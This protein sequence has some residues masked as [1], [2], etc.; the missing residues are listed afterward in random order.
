M[1]AARV[2]KQPSEQGSM[3]GGVAP[4]ACW[5]ELVHT[6]SAQADGTQPLRRQQ[7]STPRSKLEE[8]HID[9]RHVKCGHSCNSMQSKRFGQG[10]IHACHVRQG[11]RGH[12]RGTAY[13]T[14]QAMFMNC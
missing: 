10:A 1:V 8:L 6:F 12:T 2:E 9:S 7:A 4:S 13:Q 5:V 14:R 11:R 3:F